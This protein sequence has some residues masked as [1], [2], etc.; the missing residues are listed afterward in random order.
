MLS[1]TI[2][3]DIACLALA[4]AILGAAAPARAAD[5]VSETSSDN[6]RPAVAA[7]AD[8]TSVFIAWDGT[9]DGLD[10]RILLREG[11]GGYYLPPRIVDA[12][13]SAENA[14]PSIAV[15][16]TGNP[17]VAW[18]ARVG[19]TLRV[20]YRARIGGRWIEPRVVN[21]ADPVGE[22]AGAVTLRI[23]PLGM[24]W[25]AFESANQA[26]RTTIHCARIEPRSGS[27]EV[28]SLSETPDAYGLL[29]EVVFLPDPAVLWYSATESD[30]NLVGERFDTASVTW[31]PMP[32]ANTASF[33]AERMPLLLRQPDGRICAAWRDQQDGATDETGAPMDRIFLGVLDTQT[34]G[35]GAIVHRQP[36]VSSVTAAVSGERPVLCWAGE[37]GDAGPQI[38]ASGAT[39]QAG[40]TQPRQLSD[41][42]RRYYS[43]PAIAPLPDGAIAVWVSV[44]SEGGNGSIYTER[45]SF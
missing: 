29:P 37:S 24:P 2:L 14:S 22:Q 1:L 36:L 44:A 39:G 9:F 13:P 43:S 45:Y 19:A 6:A 20:M 30:F 18:I 5:Q 27:F 15:D 34:Q 16:A 3:R 38:Y 31:L 8:G 26:G 42:T 17:H 21:P 41:G 12:D 7:S 32:V 11:I 33:P 28:A 23:D 35:G 10:R 25:I 4:I 40:F